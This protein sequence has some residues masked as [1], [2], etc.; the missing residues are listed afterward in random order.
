MS[1]IEVF[2]HCE[3]AKAKIFKASPT[4]PLRDALNREGVGGFA[5]VFIGECREALDEPREV[6]DGE[7]VHEPADVT[8]SLEQ[9]EIDRHRHVHCHGCRHVAVEV[10]Y[11]SKTRRHRFSPATPISVVTQWALKKFDLTDSAA[12]DFVLQVCGTS[13]QPRP[14]EHLGELVKAPD[15][16][17]CFDIV[18]E[19]TPQG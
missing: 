8:K 18:K 5:Y 15:C 16:R 7:D 1:T 6:E 13:Q 19:I 4:E 14:N 12:A 11:N 10:N 3:G 17:I 2:L 9:L